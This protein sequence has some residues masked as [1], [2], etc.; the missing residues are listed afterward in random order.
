METNNAQ[1]GNADK[2][3]YHI[4]QGSSG[5][6]DLPLIMIACILI[7]RL[8]DH[9]CLSM[10]VIYL[11]FGVLLIVMPWFQVVK[12]GRD[13]IAILETVLH[14][15]QVKIGRYWAYY[16]QNYSRTKCKCQTANN[17]NNSLALKV[18]AWLL[19]KSVKTLCFFKAAVEP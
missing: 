14:N 18:V 9:T 4:I 15:L 10:T 1:K 6:Q 17:P 2:K 8:I 5:A 19:P 12:D 13:P 16:L 11:D 3:G 7:S